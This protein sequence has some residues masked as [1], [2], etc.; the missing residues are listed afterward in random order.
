M[1]FT[2]KT[3]L[4]LAASIISLAFVGIGAQAIH[5]SR[6]NAISSTSTAVPSDKETNDDAA[7]KSANI[8]DNGR[9]GESADDAKQ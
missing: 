7:S 3:K 2:Q 9:D 8:Q 6:V 5:A 4:V 1:I